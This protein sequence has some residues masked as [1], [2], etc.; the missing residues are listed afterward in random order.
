MEALHLGGY[1]PTLMCE[2]AG[3]SCRL[4]N[5]LSTHAL[6]S[7]LLLH[8]HMAL[9]LC[10]CPLGVLVCGQ[11]WLWVP[12]GS[13]DARAGCWEG[14]IPDM[15]H[16]VGAWG[17]VGPLGLVWDSCRKE[18]ARLGTLRSCCWHEP[19]SEV[20]WPCW[21]CKEQVCT[22]RVLGI[23]Q[24]RMLLG[25]RWCVGRLH[26]QK[27]A[28][29][30]GY[31]ACQTA[32]P[33]VSEPLSGWIQKE[34]NRVLVL[35]CRWWQ[36]L[37]GDLCHSWFLCP[38]RLAY[39]NKVPGLLLVDAVPCSS[40]P[41]LANFS[42]LSLP[43]HCTNI[44]SCSW[45]S[46]PQGNG[47]LYWS[48]PNWSIWGGECPGEAIFPPSASQICTSCIASMV[49]SCLLSSAWPKP[50][51]VCV[52]PAEPA[53]AFL[54]GCGWQLHVPHSL[55]MCSCCSLSLSPT[56]WPLGCHFLLLH[57]T[58]ASSDRYLPSL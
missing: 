40:P 22:R 27:A 9:N 54:Q 56:C 20:L 12:Q 7:C 57:R 45:F 34:K 39:R 32:T 25:V 2:T 15:E 18:P 49:D 36:G 29:G 31:L 35:M 3:T 48:G 30:V 46:S 10:L 38:A 13:S 37:P 33:P 8:T 4:P 53:L 19:W 42:A 28:S 26:P 41:F 17:D 24:G 5:L 23:K 44:R 14:I 47:L 6:W 52:S 1:A 43:L 21:G 55:V 16:D 11:G 58:S 51:S 50:N